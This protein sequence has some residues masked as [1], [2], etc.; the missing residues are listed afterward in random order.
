ML[1]L[2][3][4]GLLEEQDLHG[5]ELR[6]RLGETLG[7]LVS[8]SFGSLYPAL[9]RLEAAGAVTALSP[10][11]HER[12]DSRANDDLEGAG[13]IPMTGSLT[14][15]RAAFRG[16]R[17]P[18]TKA[19]G[20]SSGAHATGAK[21]TR[22]RRVYS[23]TGSGKEMFNRLLAGEGEPGEAED[24]RGF[25]L[26]LA[27]ARHLSPEARLR[28]LEHRRVV[29]TERLVRSTTSRS[30][31][32]VTD[33]WRKALAERGSEALGGDIAWLDRLI[34]AERARADPADQ[35]EAGAVP[36]A[37]IPTPRKVPSS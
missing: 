9:A 13:R 34:A 2:A 22:Q 5:Y 10:E 23:I 1:E 36:E 12:P 31:A 17:S 35:I 6:R 15:E 14:G 27:F 8:V 26:R 21:S 20:R 24:D 18:G 29:V 25:A 4:L 28:L 11:A 37:G 16:A 7:F 32:Q 19:A 30:A 33:T 3:I